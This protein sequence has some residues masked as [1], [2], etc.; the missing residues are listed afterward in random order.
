MKTTSLNNLIQQCTLS[1]GKCAALA[2]AAAVCLESQNHQS[3][4][5]LQIKGDYTDTIGLV[6]EPIDLKTRQSW[7]NL[8]ESVEE[9]AY[10]L[11]IITIWEITPYKVIKQGFKGSGF[12]YW[13]SKKQQTNIFPFQETARLEVSGILNGSTGQINQRLKEKLQQTKK[14]DNLDIPAFVIIAEF[15]KPIIKI[16][17]R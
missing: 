10:G 13:L 2:E 4:V 16:K 11:A 1:K 17:K 12:D 9:A 8:S 6:W 7:Q 14:S 5:S 15:S 3:G